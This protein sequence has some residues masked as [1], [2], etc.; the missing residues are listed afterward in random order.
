MSQLS[1]SKAPKSKREPYKPKEELRP[2]PTDYFRSAS[3][4]DQRA[5]MGEFK[6][7]PGRETG[8]VAVLHYL[9]RAHAP[10]QEP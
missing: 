7:S 1:R 5:A 6:G 3:Y 9:W 8:T 2:D 4:I 10:R